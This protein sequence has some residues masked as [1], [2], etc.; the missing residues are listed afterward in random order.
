M[1]VQAERSAGYSV[2]C[3]VVL[4]VAALLLTGLT[5]PDVTTKPTDLAAYAAIHRL[6]LLWGAWLT[7]PAAA[8]FLWFLVGLRSYL[9][10]A[11]GR[12][13][14]LGTFAFGAGLLAI[15]VALVTSM[16]QTAVAYVSP[17]L[18]VVD[19]IAALYVALIFTVGGLGW[20]PISIFLFAA[21]HSMRRHKSAPPGLVLLGYFA[22]FTAGVA[23]LGIFFTDP[24]MGPVGYV[25]GLLGAVPGLLWLIWTGF[26][27]IGI[28]QSG[29]A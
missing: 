28:K 16:L 22:A 24:A 10:H 2:L 5:L 12:Q 29:E 3:F 1:N 13:E 7:L 11:P 9:D 18:F 4:T 19:G 27:L 14:G 6:G 23:T 20:A 25:S 17:D 8:F 21:A 26:A 15:A